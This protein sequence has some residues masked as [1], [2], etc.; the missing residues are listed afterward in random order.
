MLPS[1]KIQ[2]GAQV[3]DAHQNVFHVFFKVVDIWLTDKNIFLKNSNFF[4][5][6]TAE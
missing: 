6:T 4:R 2:N 3:Q 5:S 1:M